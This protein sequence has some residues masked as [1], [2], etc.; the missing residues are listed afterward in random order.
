M[1]YRTKNILCS[2]GMKRG[3]SFKDEFLIQMFGHL[4]MQHMQDPSVNMC[5]VDARPKVNAY[6]NVA[7][8]YITLECSF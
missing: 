8:V 7:K 5:I 1:I 4:T 2:V 3:R 6:G